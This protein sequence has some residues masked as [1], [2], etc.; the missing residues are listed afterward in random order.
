MLQKSTVNRFLKLVP[1]AI[2]VL[3][4]VLRLVVFVQN[5]NLIIDEANIVR[6]LNERSFVELLKPLF[7]DQFAP[8][9]FLFLCKCSMLYLGAYEWVLRLFPFLCSIANLFLLYALLKKVPVG[10]AI[11][12]PLF[13]FATGMIYLR[14]ATECKQYSSDITVSLSLVLLALKYDIGLG[15]KPKFL[16]IWLFAGSIAIWLSMPSVFVL[17]AVGLYYFVQAQERK[18]LHLLTPFVAVTA[19]W[20]MQFVLYYFMLLKPS[21]ENTY[22]QQ[23][24][25]PHVFILPPLSLSDW[26]HNADAFATFFDLW[27]GHWALSFVFHLFLLCVGI[28]LLWRQDRG[29][30]ILL[31]VPFLLL[32]FA[33]AFHQFTLLPRV[34]LFVYP[35]LL[36]IM[37][38]GLAHLFSF[39]FYRLALLPTLVI[40]VIT[41]INFNKIEWLEDAP[42]F[43]RTTDGFEWLAKRQIGGNACYIHDLL[44]P[45]KIYYTTIHPDSSRWS[46]FKK[47]TI[48]NGYT[49]FDSLCASAHG[50]VAFMF[51][52]DEQVEFHHY[53]QVL[54]Q[55]F[56]LRDS[57]FYKEM[58]TF[59]LEGN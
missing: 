27:A 59:I 47:C 13:L 10:K 50:K 31:F 35:L 6:N 32:V 54:Q 38:K 29:I 16:L 15:P 36:A 51:W 25:I 49:D 12:Y 52:P 33:V 4:I 28:V 3:G 34:C 46:T 30:F 40:C 20:L 11:F 42:T 57:L 9:L 1:W 2:I 44:R 17:A 23:A 5:R 24:H 7:Y 41:M 39:T 22:L 48:F 8:P 21:T 37:G 58:K 45:Q 26:Q 53:E 43:D 55:Q 56:V 19:I 14:Y 18:N